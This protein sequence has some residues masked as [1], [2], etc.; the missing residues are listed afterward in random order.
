MNSEDFDAMMPGDAVTHSQATTQLILNAL[1]HGADVGNPMKPWDLCHRYA[2]LCLDEFFAQGDLEKAAG[3]PVQ[4]LNDRDKVNKPNS[5][6]GFIEFVI[7]PMVTVMVNIFPQLDSLADFL[8]QNIQS[9]G[10]VWQE[11]VAPSADA[12]AKVNARVQKVAN[13]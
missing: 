1:L 8:G 11:E 3:I 6:V 7:Y 13:V 9:W 5:Q 12:I 10:K 4:M 2:Y